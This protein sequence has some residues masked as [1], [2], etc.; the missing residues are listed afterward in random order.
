MIAFITYNNCTLSKEIMR[1]T[2][3]KHPVHTRYVACNPSPCA[4]YAILP[5]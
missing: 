1:F 3:Q 2:H 5:T 4:N